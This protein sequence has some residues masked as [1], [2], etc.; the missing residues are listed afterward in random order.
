MAP[1]AKKSP[2]S[3]ISLLG[4][5]IDFAGTFPPAALTVENS[6]KKAAEFGAKGV[7][8]WLVRRMVFALKDLTGL[9]TAQLQAWGIH[10]GTWLVS[11][12]GRTPESDDL[13][14]W[15]KTVEWDLREIDR[16]NEKHWDSSVR[17][18]IVLYEGKI[19]APLLGGD[20][21]ELRQALRQ[22]LDR[23]LRLRA[24]HVDSFWEVAWEGLTLK[25]LEQTAQMMT[26]WL[27]SENAPA[28]RTGLKFRT[29]GAYVPTPEQLATAIYGV[30]SNQL[31]FKATQG[32][33]HAI[34]REGAYGFVNL[35]AALTLAQALG[36]NDFGLAE[37]QACLTDENAKNFTFTDTAFRWKQHE[38]TVDD[39]E[40]ARRLYAGTF[41]S[42]SADEPDQFL[43]EELSV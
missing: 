30:T 12:L 16:F 38:L 23:F 4:G 28:H 34:S 20:S 40:T 11:A 8:P 14:G 9:T 3:V 10:G 42:C 43:T 29:G 6:W 36:G 31:R 39:I 32:L 18:G 15:L 19:P 25:K 24:L 33:H 1:S 26:D 37:I 5:V 27:E 35:F 21:D 7:H 17:T 2:Q 41:G 22:V 13:A